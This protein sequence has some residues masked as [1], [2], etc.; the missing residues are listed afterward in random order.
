MLPPLEAAFT[1]DTSKFFAE[2]NRITTALNQLQTQMSGGGSGAAGGLGGVGTASKEASEGVNKLIETLTR[3]NTILQ[4]SITLNRSLAQ[5]KEQISIATKVASTS[6]EEEKAQIRTLATANTELTTQL[7]AREAAVAALTGQEKELAAEQLAQAQIT[8]Q[9]SAALTSQINATD[10]LIVGLQNQANAL[11]VTI[12]NGGS[13]AEAQQLMKTS[14]L[15][16]NA[17]T[18]EQAAVITELRAEILS[19]TEAFEI[20]KT[21]Q[22]EQA[23][24]EKE[25]RDAALAA[26]K[27]QNAQAQVAAQEY[28]DAI[29]ASDKAFGAE[30]TAQNEA[31]TE[32]ALGIW[33]KYYATQEALA[34]RERSI[35][36]AAANIGPSFS[37]LGPGA[38]FANLGSLT[39]NV[40]AI[41]QMSGAA[42]QL[43]SNIT[44][45]ARSMKDLNDNI[46]PVD[47]GSIS[48]LS[49]WQRIAAFTLAASVLV[50]GFLAIVDALKETVATGINF[51]ATMEQSAI[52]VAA[53]L[54]STRQVVDQSGKL[55]DPVTAYNALLSQSVD[56]QQQIFQAQS[57]S[58]AGGEALL[59]VFTVIL[60][61]TGNQKASL[62]DIL[63]LS[64]RVANIE[65][66]HG[67]NIDRTVQFA[68][69]LFTLQTNRNAAELAS[70]NTT[71][72]QLRVLHQSGDEVQALLQDTKT[73]ADVTVGI[74]ALWNALTTTATTFF[75]LIDASAFSDVFAGLKEILT[76]IDK[77]FTDALQRGGL[78]SALGINPEDLRQLGVDLGNLAIKFIKWMADMAASA[79]GFATSVDKAIQILKPFSVVLDGLTNPA[80]AFIRVFGKLAD[81]LNRWAHDSSTDA[82]GFNALSDAAQ[83]GADATA[84]AWQKVADT[85]KILPGPPPPPDPAALRLAAEETLKVAEAA[86]KAAD[87]EAQFAQ[88][89][90]KV[91]G[92]AGAF[93][94]AKLAAIS[95]ETQA[96]QDQ[97]A[98]ITDI[99]KRN[100][101]LNSIEI[102][103]Q[104][105]R[106]K[107]SFDTTAILVENEQKV[108]DAV[109][110]R[111]ELESATTQSG[112]TAQA[113]TIGSNI[114]DLEQ[115]LS[116]AQQHNGTIAQQI[117]LTEQLGAA[118]V[119]Q[120]QNALAQ[121]QNELDTDNRLIDAAK[122]QIAIEENLMEL[123]AANGDTAHFVQ[124]DKAVQDLTNSIQDYQNKATEAQAKVQAGMANVNRATIAANNNLQQISTVTI[125][126]GDVIRQSLSQV[127]DAL[128]AGTLKLSDAFKSL[129]IAIIQHITDAF[130]QVI[131]NKLGFDS[132]IKQNVG[133]IGSLF[134]GLG[135]NITSIFSS[136]FG[137]VGG[138]LN[139][140]IDGLKVAGTG[141]LD[142][143]QGYSAGLNT[144]GLGFQRFFQEL[145]STVSGFLGGTAGQFLAGLFGLNSPQ[146]HIG[147]L[148]GGALGGIGGAALGAGGTLLG[149]QLGAAA[150]PIGAAVG[151]LLGT[152]LGS[153]FGDLFAHIPTKGTQ[154]RKGVVSW[155]QGLNVEF[156]NTLDSRQYG[157][158]WIKQYAKDA[159]ISF[160]DAAK[161][162]IPQNFGDLVAQGL[163]KQLLAAGILSTA[164]LA[165]KL[166]KD[167]NQTSVSFANMIAQ[168]LAG[169][170][171]KVTAFLKDFVDKTGATFGLFI[172]KAS[173]AFNSGRLD[174]ETFKA[175]IVGAGALFA[176]QIPKWLNVSAIALK[177]FT[178]DGKFDLEGFKKEL[179]DVITVIAL[180]GQAAADA[181]SQG[182]ESGA[183]PADVSKNF[184]DAVIKQI[185]D[186]VVQGFEQGFIT[187]S[188][189]DAALAAPLAKIQ[190]LISDYVSGAID[191][192]TFGQG[193]TDAMSTATPI[194]DKMAKALGIAD[195]ELTAILAQAHLLPD[196]A[197]NAG[198]AFGDMQ[199][200]LHQALSDLLNLKDVNDV[201]LTVGSSIF[202]VVVGSAQDAAA[203]MK[204]IIHQ[205]LVDAI[206]SG[207][208]DGF[209]NAAYQ[210]AA[211]AKPLA[212][213]QKL[214][215]QYVAGDITERQFETRV[216]KA[217]DKAGPAFDRFATAL[218]IVTTEWNAFVADIPA[219]QQ[220][221]ETAAASLDDLK[222]EIQGIVDSIHTVLKATITPVTIKVGDQT[223]QLVI[224]QT[225]ATAAQ[226]KQIIYG[227][228]FNS[229]SDAFIAGLVKATLESA[230]IAPVLKHIK[231]LIDQYLA[232]DISESA[233]QTAITKTLN[234]ARPAI[235][236]AANA[237]SILGTAW[238][239]FIKDIPAFNDAMNTAG[240]STQTTADQVQNLVDKIIAL[241]AQLEAIARKRIDISLRLLG[242]FAHVGTIT[243]TQA[244]EASR[245]AS[246]EELDKILKQNGQSPIATRTY[247]KFGVGQNPKGADFSGLSD[248]Q[249]QRAIDATEQLR[250]DILANYDAQKQALEDQLKDQI[251]AINK[252]YD[253]QKQ[254]S[255]DYYDG[256]K[257]ALNDQINSLQKQKDLTQKT[258]QAH[259]DALNKQL[260]LAQD[261]RTLSNDLQN[262]ITKLMASN[263]SPYSSSEQLGYLERQAAGLRTQIAGA[264]P[265]NKIALER[266]LSDILQQEL[267]LNIFQRPSPEYKDLFDSIV[268]E[269]DSMQ[270]DAAVN[271][272]DVEAIQQEIDDTT[273]EMNDTLNGIDA[274]IQALRDQEDQI[275]KEKEAADKAIEAARQAAIT[276]ATDATNQAIADLGTR[277]A[278]KLQELHDLEDGLLAEQA[279][280]AE[281]QRSDILT[282]LG[283]LLTPDQMKTILGDPQS[284]SA[285]ILGNLHKVLIDIDHLLGGVIPAATG[286]S[287]GPLASNQLFLAHKGEYVDIGHT[288][289]GDSSMNFSPTINVSVPAGSDGESIGRG[290]SQVLIHEWNQGQ[291]GRTVRGYVDRR[292]K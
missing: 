65:A 197:K 164:D 18:E 134:Q 35:M 153:A 39:Q 64:V 46:K 116:L 108:Y 146:A 160:L 234:E 13:Y 48:I 11:E 271:G 247:N 141:I 254:A 221:A 62:S 217:L 158:D 202:S 125:H 36:Q 201:Q 210:S 214:I 112:L 291:F 282:Q 216:R 31:T 208:I 81:A 30:Y 129:G 289:G 251:D 259:I 224:N 267:G 238:R 195:T 242:D 249:L 215:D 252:Q 193:I 200:K 162:F 88:E 186:S 264:T 142:L 285:L 47:D 281:K 95:A 139:Q 99:A 256:L 230:A 114:S 122:M 149:L 3:E 180:T 143:F 41:Q 157:F 7:R 174:V 175:S 60:S 191:E 192:K 115:Q 75:K 204:K 154:I 130:A 85:V 240:D 155:L 66:L 19:L 43:Q 235:E 263:Q 211:L 244:T 89:Q 68:R 5:A 237:L 152:V 111:I 135:G 133:G 273:K 243:A 245:R 80:S 110:K 42:A 54:A 93:L 276:N 176:D 101:A 219:L 227:A 29:L 74:T 231:D 113:T 61:L 9:I 166:G 102:E 228:I 104:I 52:S 16:T 127:F 90:A 167:L 20:Q 261:W 100:Q 17:A 203:Q 106:Q 165:K 2:L 59:K 84:I 147:G 73:F 207:F 187:A 44:Q 97:A 151:A 178:D 239:D 212:K 280:R 118:Q 205:S 126:W 225:K 250:T 270:R 128:V 27:E 37:P 269:L 1:L 77:A 45:A 21:A 6:N 83:R 96:E 260:K 79:I 184:K 123:Y 279:S 257:S 194:I 277:T 265:D 283:G 63:E 12:A 55:V 199:S 15:Q 163:D 92:D 189:T 272:K 253:A 94:T 23:A 87:A 274:Q 248:T 67:K 137:A 275:S 14:T 183:K 241:N 22:Q 121:A 10:E 103:D 232:G 109:K 172:E 51:N 38:S 262:T 169:D 159:N 292:R 28:Q 179:I 124:A 98:K 132:I 226:I 188:L 138:N 161:Q 156:A 150:G 268:N 120:A 229:V 148:L 25:Q 209:I 173:D 182:I 58:I 107:A 177:H 168:N 181:L 218:S 278:A 284:A 34:V 8:D 57:R 50:R 4:E 136:V 258:D 266:Q 140:V 82:Q 246:R 119:Q 33:R 222:T 49:S 220:P 171:A 91:S 72:A 105:K 198:L 190:K 236:K 76:G 185:R 290:I 287:G 223:F 53:I 56:F 117:Q 70:F 40:G 69:E 86:K 26:Q 144:T 286:F 170:P 213:I 255:D 32:E 196:A 206:Q 24:F 71:T 145:G 288:P 78:T 131:A 233:F